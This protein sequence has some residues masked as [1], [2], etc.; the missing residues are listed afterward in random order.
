MRLGVY[1]HHIIHL[2]TVVVASYPN[3]FLCRWQHVQKCRP[4][5]AQSDMTYQSSGKKAFSRVVGSQKCLAIENYI[6]QEAW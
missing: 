3:S 6:I 4:C 2:Y 1:R 5:I